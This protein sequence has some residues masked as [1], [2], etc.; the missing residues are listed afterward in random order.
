MNSNQQF[1]ALIV[2]DQIGSTMVLK[3]MLENRG[4]KCY[5]A[6]TAEEATARLDE[7]L[8]HL[9]IVDINLGPETSG[10]DWLSE[11]RK[12][13]FAFIPAVMLTGSDDE[14]TVKNSLQQ[15]VYDYVIKPSNASI[16]DKKITSW[17]HRLKEGIYKL[18][19]EKAP[20]T[21]EA[22]FDM[23]IVAISETGLCLGSIIANADPL[24]FAK[25]TSPFFEGID[26]SHPPKITFLNYE[27]SPTGGLY[28][29]RNFVQV[30]GWTEPD[31]QKIRLWIRSA[32]LGRSF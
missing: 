22:T 18:E 24:S 12:G 30:S 20:V 26:V 17:I 10:L 15:G 13:S 16:L 14:N 4:F 19:A 5:H 29:I 28:P 9:L 6:L 8:P 31:F 11:V 2:D 1:C 32:N 21:V 7:V 25:V 27:K 23:Q 3:T